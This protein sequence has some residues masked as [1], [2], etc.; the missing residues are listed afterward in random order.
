MPAMRQSKIIE[1]KNLWPMLACNT[2]CT[3]SLACFIP[4]LPLLAEHLLLQPW[5]IGMFITASSLG[6]VG[7]SQYFGSLSDRLGRQTVLTLVVTGLAVSHVIL[8][9]FLNLAERTLMTP[10]AIVLAIT[11]IRFLICGFYSA[12]PTISYALANEAQTQSGRTRLTTWT[13]V[14]IAMGNLLGPALIAA[15]AHLTTSSIF[16]LLCLFPA[17]ALLTVSFYFPEHAVSQPP[18]RYAS[19]LRRRDFAM[20]MLIAFVA[21]CCATMVQVTIGFYVQA[22]MGVDT[23]STTQVTAVLIALAGAGM[24]AGQTLVGVSRARLLTKARFGA[25][26]SGLSLIAVLMSYGFVA[27]QVGLFTAAVGIGMLIPITQLWA[28]HIA[29]Q[30]RQGKAAGNITAAQG[31]GY[32]VGPLLGTLLFQVTPSAPFVASAVLFMAIALALGLKQSRL[33]SIKYDDT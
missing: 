5:Q 28:S 10:V 30:R 2:L 23:A 27:L 25:F 8:L 24:I 29:G 7:V 19:P 13:A 32:V 31:L 21:M 16:L 33:N 9:L 12:V 20:P 18:A 4:L 26:L 6:Y 17:V 11:A 14:S 22:Q 3:L 1:L 15:V